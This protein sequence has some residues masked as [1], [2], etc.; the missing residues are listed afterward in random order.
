VYETSLSHTFSS[1][2]DNDLGRNETVSIF[3]SVLYLSVSD[4]TSQSH[5]ELSSA[6]VVN[7]TPPNR[8]WPMGERFGDESYLN[9]NV[10]E[11]F[12][13]KEMFSS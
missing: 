13:G 6:T 9:T 3:N 11:L 1:A 4:Y 7:H 12:K 5:L 8:R 2:L 10:G